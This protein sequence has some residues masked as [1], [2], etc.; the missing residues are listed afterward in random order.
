MLAFILPWGSTHRNL[1]YCEI[2]IERRHE[3]FIVFS[4][5]HSNVS[6]CEKFS[7]CLGRI[8]IMSVCELG[9]KG[10]QSCILS[11]QTKIL[12]M[13]AFILPWGYTHGI[14]SY[15]EI[16]IETR[17]EKFI[18]FSAIHGNV[19]RGEKL[20]PCLGRIMMMR[21][22]VKGMTTVCK[23]N[24]E[25]PLK[26]ACKQSANNWHKR[27]RGSSKLSEYSSYNPSACND[28]VR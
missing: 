27:L 25:E 13:P 19:G 26:F 15:C 28:E 20:S 2:Y 23:R 12:L 14:F 10:R 8:M 17:Y 21:P 7:P 4:G 24:L 11:S 6:H 9:F 18:V 5:I 22:C 16:H 3:K 1:P